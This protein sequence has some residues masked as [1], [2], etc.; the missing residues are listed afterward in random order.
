SEI[1][2]VA[3]ASG[4]VRARHRLPDRY[5]GEGL[6]WLDGRLY[7]LTWKSGTGFIYDAKTLQPLGRF[8]YAGQ[9]WGLTRCGPRLVMSNGSAELLFVDPDDFHVVRRLQVTEHGAAVDH[10]NE[11]ETI[12]GL[13]WANVWLSDDIVRI[14]P[15]SGHVIDRI[16][17]SAL[18][19]AMPDSADVLNGIAY[20][21]ARD[22][23]YVTGKYWPA[24]FR[25]ARPP[26]PGAV[27][28]N[29]SAEAR[30]QSR[31]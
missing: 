26:R 16:D 12:G 23:V 30:C 7:Q 19:A 17:A 25:I 3:P 29:A 27:A 18:A 24:L 10:L 31:L 28:Q 15:A 21:A 11:L 8:H 14:D 9:G 22:R 20:D 5:F 4:R 6:A 13:I 2:R 1:R